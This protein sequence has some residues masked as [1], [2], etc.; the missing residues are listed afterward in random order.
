M[1]HL[2]KKNLDNWVA[3]LGGNTTLVLL[4]SAHEDVSALAPVGAPG[5]FHLPVGSAVEGAITDSGHT[6]V[7][8]SGG[9]VWLIVHTARVELEGHLAGIDTDRDWTNGGDSRLQG[10]LRAVFHID[11]RLDGGTNRVLL[12]LTLL[13]DG[14]V[15][16]GSLGIDTLVGD[17][18][19]L[20]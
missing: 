18:V 11:V 14:L 2:L 6:V 4:V 1:F 8:H 12:E 19:L 20:G 16:V 7:Q 10:R 13:I 5:V 15:G 17:D 3:G 9:T